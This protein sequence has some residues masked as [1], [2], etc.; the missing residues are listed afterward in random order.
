VP[1]K[2][3][4]KVTADLEPGRITLMDLGPELGGMLPRLDSNQQPFG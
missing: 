3:D 2:S 4:G 1:T